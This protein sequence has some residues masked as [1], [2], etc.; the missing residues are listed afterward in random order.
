MHKFRINNSK[1]FLVTL[2]F[3]AVFRP[4]NSQTLLRKPV[5]FI[6]YGKIKTKA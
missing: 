6:F 5:D 2:R 4:I 1:V 3:Y